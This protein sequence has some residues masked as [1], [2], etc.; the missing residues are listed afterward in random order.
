[1]CFSIMFM[2]DLTLLFAFSLSAHRIVAAANR[3]IAAHY[4]ITDHVLNLTVHD[5]R[6]EL[7]RKREFPLPAG[8]ED[9][10]NIKNRLHLATVLIGDKVFAL[11]IDTNSSTTWVADS[12]FVCLEYHNVDQGPARCNLGREFRPSSSK[13][14]KP[15]GAKVTSRY[16]NGMF[17]EGN[18][19][20]EHIGIGGVSR[21]L[22]YF[23]KIRQIIGVAEKGYWNGHGVASGVLG[24]GFQYEQDP[25]SVIQAV[26]KDRSSLN[27]FSLA[28]K[29][30]SSPE[31]TAGGVLAFGGVPNNIPTDNH[32]AETPILPRSPE[33]PEGY[34]IKIDGFDIRPPP[35]APE[36]D[37]EPGGPYKSDD[38]I[39]VVDSSTSTVI[40]PPEVAL[41]TAS[42]FRTGGKLYSPYNKYLV[43]CIAPAP[44]VGIV[45]SGKSY[46]ISDADLRSPAPELGDNVCVLELEPADKGR[47]VL[48]DV[49]L[50]NVLA[51]FDFTDRVERRRPEYANGVL[52]IAGREFY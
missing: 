26:F 37:T 51:V 45:I 8:H 41:Y 13:T 2:L 32:W 22:P 7:L 40:V 6:A 18:F 12:S 9:L 44:R 50:R 23:R 3:S 21:A 11:A 16:Y 46:Y 47:L 49:W 24:L 20:E 36:P 5:Y 17:I 38:T 34:R 35:G 39:M 42:L 14:L 29:R 27:I 31:P 48:G 30:A 19:V 52:R 1:M 43:P 4:N 28:L 25:F 15:L 10:V 33:T